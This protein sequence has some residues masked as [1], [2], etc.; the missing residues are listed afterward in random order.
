MVVMWVGV[1]DVWWCGVKW[2][3]G[4]A[5]WVSGGVF[6]VVRVLFFLLIQF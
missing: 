4:G 3:T 2:M 5:G 6:R 1:G